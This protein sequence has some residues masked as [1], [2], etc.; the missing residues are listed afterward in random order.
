MSDQQQPPQMSEEELRAAYEQQLEEQ[1]RTLR[2]ED[3]IVQTI[4]TLV[5]LGGRRAGLAPGTEDERDPEQL[6]LSIEGARALVGLIEDQLG[7]DAT[8][9]REAL[10][11]LQMAYAQLA[12]GTPPEGGAPQGGA[13]QD[14]PQQPDQGGA[15][16]AQ[17]SGRLWVPGQ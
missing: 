2:V 15:G 10:S 17:S 4:V 8:A 1:L 16:P 3:V 12:G 5:N 9:I 11:Q 6:R 7:P 13:G 14:P